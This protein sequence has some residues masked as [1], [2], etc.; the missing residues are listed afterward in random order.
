ML[1]CAVALLET[2]L[3]LV[4]LQPEVA[5]DRAAELRAIPWRHRVEREAFFTLASRDPHQAHRR[6]TAVLEREWLAD[7]PFTL[8]LEQA[9]A[10]PP[11]QGRPL[12]ERAAR[13]QPEAAL[14]EAA[15][16]L[17]FP[18]GRA[19]LQAAINEAPAEAALLAPRVPA[20]AELVK[21]RDPATAALEAQGRPVSEP[22]LAAYLEA[23]RRDPSPYWRRAV[24]PLAAEFYRQL[25]QGAGQSPLAELD[26]VARLT[27]AS[28]AR[29]EEELEL[30]PALLGKGDPQQLPATLLR[31][32]MARAVELGR[33]ADFDRKELVDRVSQ[34][35]QTLPEAI[36]VATILGV[37]RHRPKL[38]DSVFGRLLAEPLALTP[39]ALNGAIVERFVFP[40]DDDGVESFASFRA[41][42]AG[43][44]EWQWA[45][46]EGVVKLSAKGLTIYANVPMDIVRFPDQTQDA[47]QR[48]ARLESLLPRAPDILVHRGHDYHVPRTL[49]LIPSTAKVVFLGSCRGSQVLADVVDAAPNAQIVATRGI[50]TMEVND[51]FLKAMNRHL[52]RHR[53]RLDWLAL[54]KELRQTLGGNERFRDYIPPPD[55]AA[56][57]FLA[58]YYAYL[59]AL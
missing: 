56:A 57:I 19:V 59:A 35:V 12:L 7:L 54:W 18:Y 34:G 9:Y 55:N 13:R 29:T 14:R 36:D 39:L 45:E 3:R 5:F 46:A 42:Y 51:P 38:D 33:F 50:G 27:L 52:L 48:R 17:R 2:L 8:A 37:T 41:T 26:G 47:E 58:R 53:G 43:D 30:L 40:N 22:L 4:S 49:P 23:Y 24:E 31:R 25:Q 16:C 11:A 10:L 20:I 28:L 21:F 1:L 32:V 44:P 6:I 15:T